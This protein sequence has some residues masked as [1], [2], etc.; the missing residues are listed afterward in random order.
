MIEPS[1]IAVSLRD[2]LRDIPDLVA[3]LGGNAD[4]IEVYHDGYLKNASLSKAL[5]E[6]DA[7]GILIAWQGTFPGQLNSSEVWKHQF[8][9]YLICRELQDN[10][11]PAGYGKLFRLIV[12]GVPATV[13][14][15]PITGSYV[16]PSC[17]TDL[18]SI[19]RR[20]DDAGMDHFEVQITF[21]E[22]GD[23]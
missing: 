19:Q 22:I 7:P 5:A 9:L 12:K 14:A 17:L 15:Q 8:A 2:F 18:P 10:E 11:P 23:D 4:R 20:I 16:H 6:M 3:E 1:E 21:S 13:S